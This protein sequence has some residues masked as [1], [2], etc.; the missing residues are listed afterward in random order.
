VRATIFLTRVVSLKH[1]SPR[2]TVRSLGLFFTIVEGH[3]SLVS[4]SVEA[5]KQQ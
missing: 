5:D 3:I 1:I 2:K 4:S